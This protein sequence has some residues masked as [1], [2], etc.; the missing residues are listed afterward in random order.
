MKRMKI[1]SYNIAKPFYLDES[2]FDNEEINSLNERHKEM[3]EMFISW[4][5]ERRD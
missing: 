5:E 2:R 3:I 1:V 4:I